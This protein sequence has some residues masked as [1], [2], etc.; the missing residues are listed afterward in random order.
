MAITITIL[1]ISV[2]CAAVVP[3]SNSRPIS[4]WKQFTRRFRKPEPQIALAE[5]PAIP[6]DAGW[7]L[8]HSDNVQTFNEWLGKDQLGLP[9]IESEEPS[10]GSHLLIELFDCDPASLEKVKNVGEAMRSAA[11]ESK[12]TVVADEFHEFE[13]W[14]VSGAVI[15]QESHYT[16]HTWPEHKYA[17]VDLFYC[18][19]SIYV[20]KAIDVLRKEFQPGRI[21]FLVVRR[22][23]ESEVRG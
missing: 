13:P 11:I 12:A 1:C 15:I 19:G 18:G 23:I 14:G 5:P 8:I 17:A 7:Q 20:D 22:G 2:L 9:M 3:M 16:I 21:K 4:W 10:L 6:N